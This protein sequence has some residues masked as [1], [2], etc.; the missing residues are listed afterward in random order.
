MI[1]G[2]VGHNNQVGFKN[3]SWVSFKHEITDDNFHDER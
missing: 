3:G 1:F 2:D